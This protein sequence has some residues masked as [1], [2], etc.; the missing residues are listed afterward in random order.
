[1]VLTMPFTLPAPTVSD[2]TAV[3]KSV[4]PGVD[5]SVAVTDQGG[6]SSAM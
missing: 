6:G 5:L 4:L 2:D 1:M 3:Y